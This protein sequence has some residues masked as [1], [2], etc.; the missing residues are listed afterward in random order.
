MQLARVAHE[1][2]LAPSKSLRDLLYLCTGC[3]A[4]EANCSVITGQ[5]GIINMLKKWLNTNSVPYLKGHQS[6]LNNLLKNKVPYA[7]RVENRLEW[8]TAEMKKEISSSP[9]VFYF[10]GCAS[11]FKETEMAVSLANI[12]KKLDVPFSLS[13]DEWCCGAPFN[14]LGLGKECKDWA[15]HNVELIE[16]S[17]ASIALFTCPTCS[18]IFK[19]NYPSWLGRGLPF[20]AMHVTEFLDSFVGEGRLKFTH[21]TEKSVIYH[22][23]CHLGRGQNIYDA[24]RRVLSQIPGLE[25]KEF[26]LNRENSFCCGGG[27]LLPAGFPRVADQLAGHRSVQASEKKPS[28]MVSSCPGCKENLKLGAKRAKIR[29]KVKDF[30]ELVNESL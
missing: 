18:M 10:V 21:K 12:L 23:P 19:K 5:V 1:G 30:T 7:G 13:G 28:L 27:G 8:L 9:H 17:G 4:C 2:K 11:S 20:K 26:A 25:M 29:I 3:E 14:Y 16:N 15:S 24:P 6:V 22:D